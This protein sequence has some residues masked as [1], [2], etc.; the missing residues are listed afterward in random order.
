MIGSGILVIWLILSADKPSKHLC[1]MKREREY[2]ERKIEEEKIGKR[3]ERGNPPWRKM[4]RCVPLYVAIAA[5]VCHEFPLVI[6]L[7]YL[8][9]FFSDV[10]KLKSSVNGLASSLPMVCLFI[11]KTISSSLSTIMTARKPPILSKTTSCKLFN[12]IAS[13]GLGICIGIT[14]LLTLLNHPAPVIVV[15]CLANAFAGLHTPGVQTALL[16]LAPA[17]SG[18]ITGISFAVVNMFSI[19][20]KLISSTILQNGTRHEWTIVFEISAVIALLPVV[21]FTLW[22]SAE[23][24]AWASSSSAL[25]NKEPDQESNDS[26]D[27]TEQ[28]L[29]AFAKYSLFLTHDL[30]Q[31]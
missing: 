21:F 4:A 20:N 23:R 14:P 30:G 6:M 2:I 9:K 29:H 11:S 25:P 26:S 19:S 24:Q 5:L 16:Q 27:S 7:Q 1:I 13:L 8:P 31:S 18:V 22:G 15:L 12:F 10:L 28:V 17:Y 3:T